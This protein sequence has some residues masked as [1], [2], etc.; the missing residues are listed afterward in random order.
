MCASICLFS[1]TGDQ[2]AIR[3]SIL[4]PNYDSFFD[5]A[6]PGR[7]AQIRIRLKVTLVPLDPST[8]WARTGH[9]AKL[10]GT[11]P[12]PAPPSH[13]AANQAA[14]KRGSVID[15]S[16]QPVPCRSWL[17]SEWQAFTPRFKHTVENAW[18]NQMVFLPVEKGDTLSDAEFKQLIGNPK[19]PAHVVG[20]LEVDLQPAGA[21]SHAIIE[22]AHLANP[23]DSFRDRMTRITDESV[24]FTVNRF[25]A[26][27]ARGIG[28]ETGQI[29]AAHEVGHWL[30]NPGTKVFDHVD[31]SYA[32]TLPRAQ[33]DNAQYGRTLGRYYSMMGGGSVV[34]N[35]DATPW[36]SRLRRHTPMKLGWVYVHRLHFRWSP[37]DVSARQKRILLAAQFMPKIA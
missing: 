28:G 24:L 27:R 30:R 26:G 11:R 4:E 14:I 2:M 31:R 32:L 22:V 33:Q 37:Q 15:A 16:S 13:L 3:A 5:P 7:P 12:G 29:A 8:A 18:N 6:G 10:P 20:V 34:T 25:T 35:H 1:E 36:L 9:G 17:A 23:G 21:D 19:A